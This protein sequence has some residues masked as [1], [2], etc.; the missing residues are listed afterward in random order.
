[1]KR[2]QKHLGLKNLYKVEAMY[3]DLEM[4]LQLTRHSHKSTMHEI[5]SSLEA[6]LE[7]SENS[8]LD[9]VEN[10][11]DNNN[12]QRG[13]DL[14]L[15]MSS[16]DE[17]TQILDDFQELAFSLRQKYSTVSDSTPLATENVNDQGRLSLFFAFLNNINFLFF[18]PPIFKYGS[19]Y[20]SVK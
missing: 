5:E 1:M 17:E 7:A 11:L 15:D 20:F 10:M 3:V 19:F 12:K 13:H 4:E 9:Q 16:L 2:V 14:Q 6:I 8:I 18:F